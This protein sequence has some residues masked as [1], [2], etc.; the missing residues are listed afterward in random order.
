[1]IVLS[2]R[3]RHASAVV[4][5]RACASACSDADYPTMEEVERAC[6]LANIHEVI[7]AF[8]SGYQEILG[9]AGRELSGGQR[10][11]LSIARVFLRNPSI[12]L[13][14]EVT[15]A[16]D[17][18]SEVEIQAGIKELMKGRTVIMIAHRLKT[19]EHC[20]Q[21]L[22]LHDG[23]ILERG[24]H[25]EL[26]RL[27]G[28][29]RWMVD[30]Q[31]IS[32]PGDDTSGDA[33]DPAG[34]TAGEAASSSGSTAAAAGAASATAGAPAPAS[35]DDATDSTGAAATAV[36][37]TAP[38]AAL[39]PPL[40]SL[41]GNPVLMRGISKQSSITDDHGSVDGDDDEDDDREADAS[42]A[43]AAGAS[44]GGPRSFSDS[45]AL[46]VG[47]PLLTGS[48]S[49]WAAEASARRVARFPATGT[50]SSAPARSGGAPQLVR[51]R[52]TGSAA[53]QGTACCPT[54]KRA[55]AL[56]APLAPLSGVAQ[57]HRSTTGGGE[58]A[59]AGAASGGATAGVGSSR[60]ALVRRASE[61]ESL[62]ELHDE[63]AVGASA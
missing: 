13:L 46:P 19:I 27:N 42:A 44:A 30:A 38:A 21:I 48:G 63:L 61:V 47:R 54:C 32:R 18:E 29:Y 31:A 3:A 39:L 37:A 1:M 11:R 26:Y 34:G 7:S 28:K 45:S 8:P 62:V 23:K 55:M 41:P 36:P 15:A 12:L 25:S 40:P 6:R 51:S 56:F 43:A 49:T 14:D 2:R 9:S 16:Q 10:Q 52:S 35:S 4:A 20:Q 33:A 57:S 58:G 17:V 53:D 24:N 60:R 59:A 22:L 50:P 5:C